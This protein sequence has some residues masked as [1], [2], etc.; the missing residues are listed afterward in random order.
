M[1]VNIQAIYI[2][3]RHMKIKILEFI[4]WTFLLRKVVFCKEESKNVILVKV[5]VIQLTQISKFIDSMERK[6]V[7]WKN[8]KKVCDLNIYLNLDYQ[9][10]GFKYSSLF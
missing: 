4:L 5:H 7:D 3:D 1:N 2:T 6:S 9:K 8:Q 10:M